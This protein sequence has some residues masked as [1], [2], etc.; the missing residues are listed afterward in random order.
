MNKEK[1]E[2][3]LNSDRIFNINNIKLKYEAKKSFSI[4]NKKNN[5]NGKKMRRKKANSMN[6]PKNNYEQKKETL[7]FKNNIEIGRKIKSKLNIKSNEVMCQKLLCK[8]YN[9]CLQ[10]NQKISYYISVILLFLIFP[11]ISESKS[12]IKYNSEIAIKISGTGTKTIIRNLYVPCPKVGEKACNVQ[13]INPET[14]IKVIWFNKLTKCE[15]MFS[16]LSYITEVD[17]SKF[18]SS[19]IISTSSMFQN[20][21]KLESI[22]LANFN[23]SKIVYMTSMFQG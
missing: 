6:I 21:Y 14:V 16:G 10:K 3:F 5:K 9:Y 18:D 19:E 11:I 4:K 13:L 20:C 8:K 15:Y 12:L 22:N 17:L 2:D 23:T 1:L 7:V